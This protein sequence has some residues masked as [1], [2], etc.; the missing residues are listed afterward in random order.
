MPYIGTRTTT[1]ISKE[2][3]TILKQKLGKAIETIPG[4]SEAWLM[5]EFTGGCN[6]WMR[7]DNSVDS[8]FVE[9][10]VYGKTEHRY[11]DA[12]TGKICDILSEELGISPD[13]IYVTYS[14]F[15]EWGWNGGNF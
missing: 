8:A 2:K 15:S 10:K 1:E 3:E 14:E 12:L 5:T 13:R 4:K 11:C 7:G 9:V 6:L